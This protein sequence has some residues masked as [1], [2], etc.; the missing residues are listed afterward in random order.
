[1][2]MSR[3]KEVVRQIGRLFVECDWSHFFLFIG[4]RSPHLISD[5]KCP[6]LP[7]ARHS[8]IAASVNRCGDS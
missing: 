6:A 2:L 3:L 4:D 5:G 7:I 1:M 8:S